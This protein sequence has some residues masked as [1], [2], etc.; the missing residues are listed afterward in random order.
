M[1]LSLSVSFSGLILMTCSAGAEGFLKLSRLV[2]KII[3]WALVRMS[4]NCKFSGFNGRFPACSKLKKAKEPLHGPNS[5]R[6]WRRKLLFLLLIIV[7][8]GSI[9]FFSNL[10]GRTLRGEDKTPD[11][12]E[13]KAQILLQGF[14]VSKKQLH[15]LASLFSESDQVLCL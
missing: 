5:V 15:A 6:K 10:N 13:G 12:C 4:L 14:N 3:R 1:E 8:L 11:C 2:V 7:T 9:W